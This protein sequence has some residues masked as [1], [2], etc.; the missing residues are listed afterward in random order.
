MAGRSILGE[1]FAAAAQAMEQEV[2]ST[3][4]VHAFPA[5]L[6]GEYSL[7]WTN[8]RLALRAGCPRETEAAGVGTR[9]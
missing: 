9:R 3:P 4:R 1:A 5:I 7:A 6:R 8:K 2:E